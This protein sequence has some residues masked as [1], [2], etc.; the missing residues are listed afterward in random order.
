MADKVNESI[1][2][3]NDNN[4][5]A[6]KNE[7]QS[8][9]KGVT[10]ES[11]IYYLSGDCNSMAE[12]WTNATLDSIRSGNIV[13]VVLN[14]DWIAQPDST[15]TTSFGSGNGFVSGM[16]N[17]SLN[18]KIILDLNGHSI[19][20]GLTGGNAVNYGAVVHISGKLTMID[21][22]LDLDLAYQLYEESKTISNYTDIETAANS[23]SEKL[24]NLQCG[25]ITGGN[26]TS[27]GGGVVVAS[28]ASF[29]MYSGMITDNKA[30]GGGAGINILGE[31]ALY[32]GIICNN[33][34]DSTGGGIYIVAGQY[35][36]I[37]INGGI[38]SN[39]KATYGGGIYIKNGANVNLHDAKLSFNTVFK[40]G[41]G[42][43]TAYTSIINVYNLE[44]YG[45][46]APDEGGGIHTSN[47]AKF[48]LYNSYI[49]CNYSS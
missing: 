5:P 18:A 7:T 35:N 48:A 28:Q 39:N 2:L 17:V 29:T 36:D 38:I 16:V 32:D 8:E 13:K 49:S 46:Y 22:K 34:G 45:N 11:S 44:I 40:N 12:G 42:M 24:N 14:N 47:G 1:A 20:R 19:N 3:E 27:D 26:S 23:F 31:F 37:N 43:E 25:K 41:G 15:Y 21:S 9:N 30:S 6:N 10:T 4:S 33:I